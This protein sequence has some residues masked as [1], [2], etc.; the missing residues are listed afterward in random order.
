MITKGKKAWA[1]NVII[2]LVEHSTTAYML[3]GDS[4]WWRWRIHFLGVKSQPNTNHIFS[5]KERKNRWNE[6]H[7]VRRHT[8]TTHR[9]ILYYNLLQLNK[10]TCLLNKKKTNKPTKHSSSCRFLLSPYMYPAISGAPLFFWQL[11]ND[12][13]AM[14]SE[15]S[16]Q[17]KPDFHLDS[18]SSTQ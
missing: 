2:L 13:G 4:R 6:N 16:K 3:G 11:E 12:L 1:I 8:A 15:W 18:L 14:I 5:K 9:T 17:P 10:A 7:N